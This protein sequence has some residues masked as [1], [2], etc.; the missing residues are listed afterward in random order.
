MTPEEVGRAA[1]R[2]TR[3][4]WLTLAGLL[5]ALAMLCVISAV[6]KLT[7]LT[8]T[9]SV[10]GAGILLGLACGIYLVIVVRELR[11]RNIF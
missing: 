7:P 5:Q 3:Q 1:A 11:Q 2:R 10:G 9:F 6:V 4:G 8:M